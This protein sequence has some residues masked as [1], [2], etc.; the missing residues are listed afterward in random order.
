M[1]K[2]EKQLQVILDEQNVSTNSMRELIEAFGAPFSEAGEILMTYEDIKVTSDDQTELMQQAREQRLTLKR[3]RTGV[4]N[5][6]KE[7]KEDALKAGR[8][9]DSV[10]RYIRENIEPAEKYLE[11]QEKFV[12][13]KKKAEVEAKRAER[14][15]KLVELGAE[16]AAYNLDKMT[17]GMFAEIIK[18]LQAKRDRELAEQAAA[19]EAARKAEQERLAEEKRMREENARL[20]AEAEERAK[21]EA[22]ERAKAE[23]EAAAAERERQAEHDRIQ[24]IVIELLKYSQKTYQQLEQADNNAKMLADY[25]TKLPKADMANDRV[26]GAYHKSK[27]DIA[28]AKQFI[29]ALEAKREEDRKAAEAA[30]AKAEAEEAERQAM[31]APDKEKLQALA[32]ELHQFTRD[33]LP[34][35]KSKAASDIVLAIEAR[36]NDMRS[37]IIEKAKGL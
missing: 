37:D 29:I 19:E 8:A 26:S 9:I 12:E 7:L 15:Q 16:P 13:L 23:A 5:K 33:K 24:K 34:A 18:D 2:A 27:A 25:Y 21:R 36:L 1:N 28:E 10:A 6:R 14:T 3:I 35:V 32:E 4:E 20:K 31:L 11:L 22:E 17:D 30:A